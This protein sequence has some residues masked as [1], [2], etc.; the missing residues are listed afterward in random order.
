MA[1]LDEPP[2]PLPRTPAQQQEDVDKAAEMVALVETNVQDTGEL[3]SYF[4]R[5]RRR[6]QLSAIALE[7][8]DSGGACVK[9]EINPIARNPITE[10]LRGDGLARPDGLNLRSQ[11]RFRSGSLGGDTVG[12]EME[13]VLRA[14]PC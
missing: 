4:P 8:Q 12:T 1:T 6:F 14:R 2:V 13:A 10:L 11:I 7:P 9:V 3:E 5:I